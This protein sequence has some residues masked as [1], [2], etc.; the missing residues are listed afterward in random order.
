MVGG[1]GRFHAVRGLY[2]CIH[3]ISQ[4]SIR[5]EGPT[6]EEEIVVGGNVEGIIIIEGI[7]DIGGIVIVGVVEGMA[8]VGDVKGVF[9]G[10]VKGFGRKRGDVSIGMREFGGI[11]VGGFGRK[12]GDV[13]MESFKG[14]RFKRDALIGVVTLEGFEFEGVDLKWVDANGIVCKGVN[15]NGMIPK[16]L[17][18]MGRFRKGALPNELFPAGAFLKESCPKGL[19]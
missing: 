17:Q 10:V 3:N 8:I 9:Q 14:S 18:R 19:L 2:R 6:T 15:A 11:V 13:S 12:R 5:R 16:G 7:V 4:Q 1:S